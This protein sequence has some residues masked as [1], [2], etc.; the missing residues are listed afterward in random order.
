M[1]SKWE[2]ELAK[3]AS[4][5]SAR[6][7]SRG[8]GMQNKISIK[9]R[10]Y[11]IGGE[12][13]GREMDVVIIDFIY[14]NTLYKGKYDPDKPNVP[15]CFAMSTGENAGDD[16]DEM[17][18]HKNVRRPPADACA[19]CPMNE[20]GSGKGRAKACQGRRRLALIH[21]DDIKSVEDVEEA[22]IAIIDLPVTGV[23]HW[24]KYLK[25]LE[26][27]L[28]RPSYSV[29]T[30]MAFDQ[31]ESWPVPTYELGE[32][33]KDKEIVEAI[34]ARIDEAQK[35]AL[36]PFEVSNS[37]SKDEDEDEDEDEDDEDERPS[38]RKSKS[39]SSKK[40]KR[41]E[42]D[43]DDDE[44]DDDDDDE[45]DDEDDEEEDEEDD[46]DDD[47]DDEDSKPR[48][49]GKA[50]GGKRRARDDDDDDDEDEDDEDDDDE[51]DEE[52]EPR[53]KGKRKSG[54]RFGK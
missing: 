42:E 26:N 37:K 21:A 4:K 47:E 23:K 46:D 50:G 14:L 51:D 52:D 6:E 53:R 8:G 41:D 28:H 5:Q 3:K 49:R 48:R 54:S 36:E 32:K 15:S 17:V 2:K 35:L 7:K 12:K 39:K 1:T 38:R 9:K 22:E 13:L 19:D 44:E 10:R 27:E 30:H 11:T 33:I 29:V 43:D 16:G 20:W 34:E 18:P 24:A 45:D 31:D 25:T 40:R